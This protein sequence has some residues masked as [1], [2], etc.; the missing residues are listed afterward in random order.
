MSGSLFSHFTVLIEGGNT[1]E[2]LM[3]WKEKA[4]LIIKLLLLWSHNL[5]ALNTY[6]IAVKKQ[7]E[8]S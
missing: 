3:V 4:I 2:F 1:P 6:I 8:I 7:D 5:Q